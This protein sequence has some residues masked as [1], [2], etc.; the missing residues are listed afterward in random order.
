MNLI[1]KKSRMT[2]TER[3]LEEMYLSV[4]RMNSS[5]LEG[6]FKNVELEKQEQMALKRNFFKS[7][8]EE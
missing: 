7:K 3:Y 4:D 6:D 1:T 8:D 5:H 2:D